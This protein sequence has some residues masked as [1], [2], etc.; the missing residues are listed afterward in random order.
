MMNNRI[1]TL[2]ATA[3]AIAAGTSLA[4]AQSYPAAPGSYATAAPGDYRRQL[5]DFDNVDEE[6]GGPAGQSAALPPPGPVMS[7]D[8]PRYGRPAAAPV[9]SE[10]AP[11]PQGPVMSP[12]DPRYGR[13]MAAPTY[14]D[15]GAAPQGPVMSPDDPRY[16]RPAGPPPV[17]Y[18]NTGDGSPRP[19]EGVGQSG[20]PQQATGSVQSAPA[21]GADGRPLQVAALPPED[22]PEA[23]QEFQLPPNLRRQEVAFQT[24]E[25]A[26]TIV[27]D[28]SHTYLY[29]VLGNGR[30]MRYGVRV[31]RDGFT[32]TGVQK[33]TRKA[34]WPDWHPPTE[35][36]ERQ[37][38]LPRFMAGGPGNPL[39]ARA[40]YLGSTVYRIHGTNQPSTI[41]KFVSS[42]CIGMLNEDVSD[43]FER[44]K[45]GTRVVVLPGGP[46]PATAS[47]APQPVASAAPSAQ[48][49]MSAVP[50]TQ[51]TSVAPLPAPVTI[52]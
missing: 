30:A 27:V 10:R 39:G 52:R 42:G 46:P 45:V 34:E 3:A 23:N 18:S 15:R 11:A 22:Q 50:G 16:G 2:L 41:G 26:G 17:I 9:Y 33:I 8:D 36:I 5:P 21:L 4:Q 14:S 29:Y 32:W 28:T 31:G 37:P 24:K 51:P 49:Q 19:P 44:A 25:P 6:D 38:Y 47:A 20:V 48:P 7:P 43:L 13:P 1:L 35:M 40:M 12:D